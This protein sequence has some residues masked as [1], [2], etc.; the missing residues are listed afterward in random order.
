VRSA[1]LSAAYNMS[2]VLGWAPPCTI[3][4]WSHCMGV[5]H[6]QRWGHSRRQKQ[7]RRAGPGCTAGRQMGEGG[8]SGHSGRLMEEAG[9]V[10]G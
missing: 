7:E 4:W 2:A 1:V 10:G 8:R 5:S 6:T 9:R 3:P